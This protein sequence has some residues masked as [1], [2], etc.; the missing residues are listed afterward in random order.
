MTSSTHFD[1]ADLDGIDWED[2]SSILQGCTPLFGAL[3][4]DSAALSDLVAAVGDDPVLAALCEGYDFMHKIVLHERADTGV[5][6]RLHLYRSGFFDRPHN[7]RWS[8][9]SHVLRGGYRHRVYGRD[10]TFGETTDVAGLTPIQERF[11][12]AGATY[13]LHHTSVHAVSAQ[14]DTVSLI[15]RGPAAK[16]RFLILDG[17]TGGFLWASGAV[18]ETEEQRAAKRLRPDQLATTIAAARHLIA[19]PETAPTPHSH[20]GDRM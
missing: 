4:R 14:A 3:S 2:T 12:P 13:A 7:H 16:E 5:R 9:A 17:A 19:L 6:L 8:F 10:D 1:F 15:V 20:T 11:E 18:R